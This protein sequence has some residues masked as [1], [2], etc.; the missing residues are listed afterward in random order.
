M[1]PRRCKRC[2]DGLVVER[3]DQ[4]GAYLVCMSCGDTTYPGLGAPRGPGEEPE[5]N[6]LS[7]A[8]RQ[9]K[10]WRGTLY[11]RARNFHAPARCVWP[12]CH[13]CGE[14]EECCAKPAAGLAYCQRHVS[15]YRT[16]WGAAVPTWAEMRLRTPYGVAEVDYSVDPP[17]ASL[18]K[19]KA[20]ARAIR[21]PG[22]NR[23]LRAMRRQVKERFYAE[24][25][26]FIEWRPDA[27][28]VVGESPWEIPA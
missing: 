24:T 6:G 5:R 1:E 3:V 9:V 19:G 28:E 26:R 15:A 7:D 21:Y 11:D 16:E 27:V 8:A 4:Y 14:G 10:T 25:G 17:G 23:P 22:V 20:W 13:H 18:H 2:G 12:D